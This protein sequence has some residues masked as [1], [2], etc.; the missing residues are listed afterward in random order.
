M[1]KAVM[2]VAFAAVMMV[3]AAAHAGNTGNGC[4]G[5]CPTTNNNTYNTTNKGGTGIGIGVAKSNASASVRVNN[6]NVNVN[7][8]GQAQGQ[9]QR[10]SQRQGQ[11]QGQKQQANNNGNSQ[12]IEAAASSAIAPSINPSATCQVPVTLGGMSIVG[13]GSLG[14]TYT[15]DDCVKREDTRMYCE[16]AQRDLADKGL[17][18]ALANDLPTVRAYRQRVSAAK[19]DKEVAFVPVTTTSS[20]GGAE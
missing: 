1:R 16:F 17:C 2:A 14:T 19:G 3:G 7:K 10:Q 13:G 4:I 20:E 15:S 8:Q 5:N 11:E 18:R 9:K 6:T 12:T